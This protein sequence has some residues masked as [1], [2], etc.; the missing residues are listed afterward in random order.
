[1]ADLSPYTPATITDDDKLWAA[2]MYAIP[3]VGVGTLLLAKSKLE[4]QY[5]HFHAIQVTALAVSAVLS[6]VV[7]GMC[8]LSLGLILL[9]PGLLLLNL[10]LAYKAYQGEIFELPVITDQL[11]SRGYL[12]SVKRL[13]PG[14]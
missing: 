2:V 3:I 8:T 11:A 10:F 12:D 14:A 5:I 13:P 4:S 1:M 6:V 9:G 7:I